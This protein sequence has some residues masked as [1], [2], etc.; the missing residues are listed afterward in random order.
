[1]EQLGITVSGTDR[2]T[3]RHVSLRVTNEIENLMAKYLSLSIKKKQH[4]TVGAWKTLFQ[5]VLNY[6]VMFVPRIIRRIRKD[7]QSQ[8]PRGLRRRSTA[9]LLLRSWVRIPLGGM[10]VFLLCVLSDTSRCD[11]LITRPEESYRLWRVVVCD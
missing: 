11:E 9:A 8:W 4:V 5:R 3:V 1:M 7:R 6:S 2:Q 10:D